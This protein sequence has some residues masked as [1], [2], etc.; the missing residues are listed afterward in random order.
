MPYRS[1]QKQEQA[2]KMNQRS[3]NQDVRDKYVDLCVEENGK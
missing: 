2:L 3:R 1:R